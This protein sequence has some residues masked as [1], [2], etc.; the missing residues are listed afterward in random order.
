MNQLSKPPKI[1]PESLED[2]LTIKQLALHFEVSYRAVQ[3]AAQRGVIPG[4]LRVMGRF[5]FD[6]EVTLKEW[7]PSASFKPVRAIRSVKP[8]L[9]VEEDLPDKNPAGVPTSGGRPSREVEVKYLRALSSQVGPHE[10]QMIISKAVDQ[11]IDGDRHARKWLSDYLMG[12]PT[13][14]LIV[15]GNIKTTKVFELGQRA[16]AVRAILEAAKDREEEDIVE[17]V[18]EDVTSGSA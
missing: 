16:A 13:R 17:G 2:W 6:P 3:K 10:W 9:I 7:S 15:D 8:S 4:S 5:L 18:V 14:H 1:S 11:A 12:T